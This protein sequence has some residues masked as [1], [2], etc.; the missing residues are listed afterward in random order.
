MEFQWLN[1]SEM[2]ERDGVI[3]IFA[4]EHTDFF[5]NSGAEA[6]EGDAV[7]DSLCNAPFYYTEIEGDFVLRVKVSHDFKQT[8]DSCSIMVFKDMTHWAKACFE[9]TDFGW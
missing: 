7:P 9:L 8:Y 2:T 1:E 4:P 5:C 3:S 6:E